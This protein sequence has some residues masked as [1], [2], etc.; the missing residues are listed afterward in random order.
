MAKEFTGILLARFSKKEIEKVHPDWLVQRGP[1]KFLKNEVKEKL[2]EIL[3][4]KIY[5]G[6][7]ER[8][9][10][11]LG[12]IVIRETE[13]SFVAMAIAEP[14][15]FLYRLK[16]LIMPKITQEEF[17]KRCLEIINKF[18]LVP[19]TPDDIEKYEQGNINTIQ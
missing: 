2:K 19:I 17:E 5:K 6:A 18:D 12:D 11:I 7:K 1:V 8:K 14:K 9:F 16:K 4:Q 10:K 15:G 13:N 3:L